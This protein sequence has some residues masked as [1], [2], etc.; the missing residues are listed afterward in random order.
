MPNSIP[1]TIDFLTALMN[2][3]IEGRIEAKT[4]RDMTPEQREE[5]KAKLVAEEKG[6]IEKGLN[7]HREPPV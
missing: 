3:I 6:E 1:D 7:R 2:A 4:F 5:Y